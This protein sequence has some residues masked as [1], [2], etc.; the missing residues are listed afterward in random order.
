MNDEITQ[1][2]NEDSEVRAFGMNIDEAQIATRHGSNAAYISAAFTFLVVGAAMFSSSS[3]MEFMNDPFNFIDV[4][5]IAGLAFG[6]R[7]H[8][9]AAAIVMFV[10]FVFSKILIAVETGAMG[11]IAASL[12]FLYF[13]GG[14]IKGSFAYHKIRHSVDPE[15]TPPKKWTYWVGIPAG[16][17]LIALLTLGVLSEVGVVPAISVVN[18]E[19]LSQD[20]KN[21][22]LKLGVVQPSEEIELFYSA[23]LT[24]ISADGNLLTDQRIISYE[25]LGDGLFIYSTPYD[26]VDEFVLYQQGDYLNDTIIEIWPE[27]QEGFRLYLSTD[28]GGDQRF[29]SAIN[30]RLPADKRLIVNAAFE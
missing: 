5:L 2:V 17:I 23:G 29:I 8:S 7:R 12:V 27:A 20:D 16:L 24:S 6:M 14:A 28:E 22:L 3:A 13:F 25:E 10:Y 4:A 30:A 26:E 19:D 9:R 1:V 15:Y 11:G 21:L 18:G